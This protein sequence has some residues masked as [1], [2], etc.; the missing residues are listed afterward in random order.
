VPQVVEICFKDNTE[1]SPEVHRIDLVDNGKR[2]RKSTSKVKFMR[3]QGGPGEKEEDPPRRTKSKS[4]S[5]RR[6]KSAVNRS[7][8]STRSAKSAK[9]DRSG[10]SKKS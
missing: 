9:S 8:I 3:R 4:K 6:S 7:T 10:G 1:A 5:K 2:A